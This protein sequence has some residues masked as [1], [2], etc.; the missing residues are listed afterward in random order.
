VT[1]LAAVLGTGP[2][3]LAL[4]LV[5]ALVLAGCGSGEDG[6]IPQSDAEEMLAQVDEIDQAV[7]EPDCTQAQTEIAQL[8]GQVD[9]LPDTVGT[10][11]KGE[12]FK[13]VE[14]MEQQVTDPEQC[15]EPDTGASGEEAVVPEEETTTPPVE[16][17]VAPPEEAP[18]QPE[19]EGTGLPGPGN[20]DNGPPGNEGNP[21]S[22]DSGGVGG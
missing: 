7:E 4:A 11:T 17:A 14:R 1:R 18:E 19:D 5:A 16:E 21:G 20:S 8:R 9:A 22:G 6:T 12:L 3:A 13:L 15:E 10:E 2:K